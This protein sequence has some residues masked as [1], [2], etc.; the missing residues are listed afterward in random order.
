MSFNWVDLIVRVVLTFIEAAVAFAIVNW[1]G[2]LGAEYIQGIAM[3]GVAAVVSFLINFF[4]QGYG[5]VKARR[6]A[7][8]AK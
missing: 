5:V 1:A 7:K 2:S 8:K 3:A 4:K 6:A